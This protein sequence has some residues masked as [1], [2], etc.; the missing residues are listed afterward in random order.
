MV[1][2][3]MQ[4]KI[5]FIALIFSSLT[6]AQDENSYRITLQD[7]QTY[8]G[9]ILYEDNQTITLEI[10]EG[11]QIMI[12]RNKIKETKQIQSNSLKKRKTKSE[13]NATHLFVA[14]TARIQEF[15]LGAIGSSQ[16]LIPSLSISPTDYLQITGGLSFFPDISFKD[17]FKFISPKIRIYNLDNLHLGFGLTYLEGKNYHSTSV[18]IL[19]TLDGNPFS[20]TGG[21]GF[22]NNKN[23]ISHNPI[24]IIGIE[25]KITETSKLISEN[26]MH[27]DIPGFTF[28][29]GFRFWRKNFAADFGVFTNTSAIERYYPVLPYVAFEYNF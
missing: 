26:W 15:G 5:L 14:P 1:K 9:K 17:Q 23:R 29:V 8:E 16:I 7:G 20:I 28:S 4:M 24:F 13:P 25:R 2:R 19:S 21:L 6:L 27:P 18:Y 12:E 11:V 22:V 3:N 10:S